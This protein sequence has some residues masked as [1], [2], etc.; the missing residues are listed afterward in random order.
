[1]T[2][3]FWMATT[4]PELPR[5]MFACDTG[6][7]YTN[8]EGAFTV[9]LLPGQLQ[10]TLGGPVVPKTIPSI[11]IDEKPVPVTLVAERGMPLAGRVV[12]SD[13]SPAPNATVVLSAPPVQMPTLQ[14]DNGGNFRFGNA[15]RG[16]VTLTVRTD[17]GPFGAG[18]G[19]LTGGY[20]Q[21]GAP[22]DAVTKQVNVPA[23]DVVLTLPPSGRITG[24][25]LDSS[26]RRPITDFRVEISAPGSPLRPVPFSSA[27]GTFTLEHV[28]AGRVDITAAAIG[29]V[30][31]RLTG[32]EVSGGKTT[33]DVDLRLDPAGRVAGRVT[34]RDGSTLSGVYVS[35]V[36]GSGGRP[37]GI[38]EAATT[39][40]NGEFKLESVPPGDQRVS[41]SKQGFV[42]QEKS[43]ESGPG[44]ESRIDVVLDPG[45]EL[46]GRV[47][48]ES[49]Q[50]VPMANIQVQATGEGANAR[51]DGGG[52][53][54]VAGLRDLH[55][56]L[57]ARKSGYVDA[58]V[59]DVVP[60]SSGPVTLTMRRGGSVTGR[61]TNIPAGAT[62]VNVAL[63]G[64][65][66]YRN[67][68]V[69]VASGT[70]TIDGVPD[71]NFSAEA[72][73]S[74]PGG[75]GRRS[76]R[77][78]VAVV[79]GTAPP[80]EIAFTDGLTIHGRV[81][82][83]GQPLGGANIVFQPTTGAG[84]YG[85]SQVAADGSYSVSGIAEGS[86][87]VVVNMRGGALYNEPYT[88]TSSTVYDVDIR[89][90]SL[91]GRV[92]GG[93]AGSPVTNAQVSL[94]NL[95]RKPLYVS[96]V[97][98]DLDGN[99]AFDPVIEGRWRLTVQRDGF[100]SESRDVT[101][102]GATTQDVQMS[103]GTKLSVTLVDAN[104]GKPVT[105]SVSALDTSTRKS[106]ASGM[107]RSDGSIDLWLAPGTYAVSAGASQY[108]SDPL[109]VSAP[110]PA[111]RIPM[112]RA[113]RVVVRWT[114]AGVTMV[115]LRS[116]ASVPVPGVGGSA[117]TSMSRRS[118][119]GSFEGIRPGQYTV[120]LLG[121]DGKPLAEQPVGVAGGQTA[122]VTFP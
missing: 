74:V 5:T 54:T 1:M 41:F 121:A 90:G 92:T 49:G 36:Q 48:D 68:R 33:A 80:L 81:T 108:F 102:A 106:A 38:A 91:R 85:N 71:G 63:N 39:D 11:R 82:M 52:M 46:R 42:R 64:D 7:C 28:T 76:G 30:R 73:A 8:D 4:D 45:L 10:A 12:Y 77:V 87:R 105:G 13:G 117:G 97:Y 88:V 83:Q 21:S 96:A 26:T 9:R 16:P 17:G 66:V 84:T 24:V 107:T 56:S 15:P 89:A 104:D 78:N 100:R 58:R 118:P 6:R 22:V 72:M 47:V 86:F 23:E 109:N 93:D 65:R 20:V 94:G 119:T 50:A 57:V 44:K 79:S 55:Y 62:F 14:T 34:A 70:F 53:F 18:I 99:Y 113:G 112:Q 35:V 19:G 116:A 32:I 3:D 25:V 122:T 31:G 110:G 27:D 59:D 115:Q 98:T 60:G 114:R 103:A 101:I 61:V 43:V 40:S 37:M 51:S 29:Y 69:D 2:V 75:S 120:Q 111:V 67:G 95:D